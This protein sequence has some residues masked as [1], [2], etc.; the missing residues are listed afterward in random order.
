[1]HMFSE[2]FD[3]L[4]ITFNSLYPQ[5]TMTLCYFLGYQHCAFQVML[6]YAAPVS[7]YHSTP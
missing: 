7:P 3:L 5:C 4:S 6:T 1:M 2:L